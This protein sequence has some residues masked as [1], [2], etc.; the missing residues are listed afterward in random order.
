MNYPNLG[1]EGKLQCQ[2]E[3]CEVEDAW[4]LLPIQPN[5]VGWEL[6]QEKAMPVLLEQAQT[7]AGCHLELEVETELVGLAIRRLLELLHNAW[8][9]QDGGCDLEIYWV[10]DPSKMTEVEQVQKNVDH[11]SSSISLLETL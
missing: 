4:E 2:V 10:V 5:Q 6:E 1:E 3:G 7:M 11:R 9:Q 8:G